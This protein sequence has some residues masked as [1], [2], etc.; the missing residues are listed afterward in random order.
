MNVLACVKNCGVLVKIIMHGI[1]VHV[2]V[3][4]TKDV[5]LVNN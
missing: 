1:L 5:G 2:I 4:V 3:S